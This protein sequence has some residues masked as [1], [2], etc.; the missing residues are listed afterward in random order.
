MDDINLKTR[1][2]VL[3]YSLEME[4][5]INTLLLGHL[6]IIE[7][8]ETKNFG[9]K[10]G[11]SFKSKIDLLYDI[12][13]LNLEEHKNLDL[14]MNF[15][16]KFLHDIDSVSFT[17]IL[18]DIDSGI[19]NRFLKFL[20]PNSQPIEKDYEIACRN[21]YLHN[22][23]V[24]SKKYEERRE[25]ITSRT[26]YLNSLFE[27]ILSM[28]ELSSNLAQEI[29]LIVEKSPLENPLIMSTLEPIMTNCLK[30]VEV[31]KQESEKIDKLG[32]M[33]DN[34]PKRKMII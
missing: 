24:I 26:N 27:S 20:E 29:M 16:N 18:Q 25:S 34:L 6:G 7:K 5:H 17:Y 14:L 19:K 22:L 4:N 10:A 8:N 1:T 12:E 32:E 9:K 23:K 21:L 2:D 11:I 33:Y 30:F 13:V 28:N 31:Y 3:E 15:R